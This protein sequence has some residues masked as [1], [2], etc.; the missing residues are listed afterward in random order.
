LGINGKSR[1]ELRQPVLWLW[2]KRSSRHGTLSKGDQ[3]ATGHLSRPSVAAACW[4][5]TL[6]PQCSLCPYS[7]HLEASKE[8]NNLKITDALMVI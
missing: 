2:L 5:F 3:R 4:G 8:K 6:F 1:G 7:D